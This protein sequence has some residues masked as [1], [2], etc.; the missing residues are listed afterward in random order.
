MDDLTRFDGVTELHPNYEVEHVN[1]EP[2]S[3]EDE[4]GEST[5]GLEQVNAPN[6]W[7]D[8][9]TKG[10]GASVAVLDTG[11]DADHPEFDDFDA[12]ENWKQFDED[13]NVMDVAPNDPNGHGTHVAG[14]VVG[15][16]ESGTNIGV[17]PEAEL[18]AGKVLDNGGTL[19]QIVAGVEWAVEEDVDVVN[20]SL[21]GG[22]YAAVYAEVIDN[23][24]DEGTLVVSSSGN[25]GPGAEGTPANVYSALAVGA[26]DVNEDIADFS[27]GTEIDTEEEWGYIGTQYDWPEEFTT[28]D[29]AAP[30][31]GI[32]SSVPGD[33]Y[34]DTYSGTS[35]A[36]PHASGVAALL[37]AQGADDAWDVK[38]YMQDSAEKPDEPGFQA[39]H[40]ANVYD[41]EYDSNQTALLTDDEE[42]DI[43]YGYG[44]VDAYAASLEMKE[45]GTVEGTVT[46][47]DGEPA[48]VDVWVGAAEAVTDGDGEFSIEVEAGVEHDIVAS[49]FGERAEETVEVDDGEKETV[50]LTL[51]PALDADLID[52]QAEEIVKGDETDISVNVSELETLTVELGSVAENADVEE[53]NI[54][55]E[56]EGEELSLGEE[57][58]ITEGGEPI[59]N[60]IDLTVEIDAAVGAAVDLDLTF[61]NEG[62]DPI[63]VTTGP[64][65]VLEEDAESEDIQVTEFDPPEEAEY[66]DTDEVVATFENP[67]DF[68]ETEE[69]YLFVDDEHD[70]LLPTGVEIDSGEEETV[71]LG[72]MGWWSDLRGDAVPGDLDM[73]VSVQ[74]PPTLQDESN[75]PVDESDVETITVKETEE[76]EEESIITGQVTDSESD[77]PVSGAQVTVTG[78]DEAETRTDIDGEFTASIAGEGNYTVAVHAPQYGVTQ[79]HISVDA[80]GETEV[81]VAITQN[82][83]YHFAMQED[84]VYSFGFPGPVEGE[85]LG[86]V[87]SG[88]NEEEPIGTVWTFDN[89]ENEWSTGSLDTEIGA[90]DAVVVVPEEEIVGE[91]TF[92][93]DPTAGTP[94]S[95]VSSDVDEG[96]NFV[97][98]AQFND[99]EE[100]FTTTS[101][102]LQVQEAGDEP[103]SNVLPDGGFGGVGV[104]DEGDNDLNP[105]AGYFLA[106][107]DDGEQLGTTTDG[108]NLEEANDRLNVDADDLEL[109]VVKAGSDGEPIEGADVTIEADGT[110]WD[111]VTAEDGS[112]SVPQ[113]PAEVEQDVVVEANG[114]ETKETQLTPGDKTLELTADETMFLVDD[115]EVDGD[116]GN[117]GDADQNEFAPGDEIQ[118]DYEV[119]NIGPE[120]DELQVQTEIGPNPGEARMDSD[121]NVVHTE[122]LT[123]ENGT[124]ERISVTEDILDSQV[125]GDQYAAGLSMDMATVPM[126]IET[127]EITVLADEEYQLSNLNPETT[128]VHQEDDPF[129]VSVDVENVGDIAEEPQNIEL[130]ILDSNEEIAYNETAEAVEV[131]A[132]ESTTVE[133]E[134]IDPSEFDGGEY[135]LV[136]S[137]GDDE[138]TGE[139]TVETPAMSELDTLDIADEDENATIVEGDDENISVAVENVGDEAGEFDVDLEINES[140]V[141]EETTTGELEPGETETVTFEAVTGNLSNGSYDIDVSTEDDSVEG[142]LT[143]QELTDDFQVEINDTHDPITEGENLDVNVTVENLGTDDGE[144]TIELEDFGGENVDEENVSLS[145]SDETDISL[146][147][148]TEEGDAGVDNITVTSDNDSVSTEVE[149]EQVATGTLSELDIAEEGTDAMIV[150]GDNENISVAVENVGDE[151]GEFDVNL[152]I[153]ES[154]VEEETTT[155]ELEPDENETV[156]FE[157]VTGNLSDGSYDVDVS[158]EDDSVEGDLT[159]QELTDDFQVEISDTSDPV[160]EGENLDVNVTVENLGTD[161]GEQ[162]IELEDFGGEKVDEENV[163]LDTGDETNIT[164]TWETEEGDAGVDDITVTSDNDS[165]SAGVEIE[166][167][168]TGTLSDLNIAEKSDNATIVE[169]DDENISVVVENVG[170]EAGEFDVTLEINESDI[171]EESSIDEL[172]PDENETITFEAVT[173]NLSD[174]SYDVDVSTEDDTVEGYLTVQELTDDFQIEISD[175]HDPVT[176][177]ENLDVDATVENVGTD[178]GEQT[179]E[180]EDFGGENVD[181]ETVSL[182][183]GDETNITLTWETEE[184]DAGADDITV[185]SDD[186]S[187]STEI[188][189]EQVATAALS[190]L[191][192]AGEGAD[193]TIV[194][195]DNENVSVVVENV[196]DEAGEFDVDLEIGNADVEEDAKTDELEPGETET[197]TFEAVTGNLSNG[198]YDVDV[199]TEDDSIEG[200]LIVEQPAVE[201]VEIEPAEDQIVEAGE[202][203]DFDAT[204][205]DEDGDELET[206]DSEFDWNNADDSGVF[207]E[208]DAGNYEVTAEL[209]GV[210]SETTTVTVESNDIS[211]VE[212][213]PA[214]NQTVAPDEELEFDATALDEFD[215]VVEDNDT[216]FTWT[217]ADESGTFQESDKDDYTVTAELGGVTSEVTTV[218]V[219]EPAVESVEIEP[220]EERTVEAGETIDFDATAFD[221]DGDELETDDSEF[222]WNNADESGVFDETDAGSYD[223]T[224]EFGGVTSESTTVTV[225]ASDVDSVEIDPANDRTVAPDEELE[226]G[227]TALD[228]FDNVVEDDDS[229]FTW[230][231][232]DESGTFQESDEG[233]Y[234]VSAELGGVASESTTVT[235]DS[236]E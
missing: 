49:E 47:A 147:W 166:Q 229:A 192:I 233:D 221:E 91:V 40:D 231:N 92:E 196:G 230:T 195:D 180:L 208:T 159:V 136:V 10:G 174:G 55:V 149:I 216:E 59:S 13:G 223:V 101:E 39:S 209:G 194:E 79:E 200:T 15:S 28:P 20:M 17:A 179:I 98:P 58:D 69:V 50:D 89:E 178:D 222:D 78:P 31:V 150:E 5:Y 224:A 121:T 94:G 45:S 187:V 211:S 225:E 185:T 146:T 118:I 87:L 186:D 155:D 151:A 37:Y 188:E 52:D 204:A 109:T 199:S 177:G 24:M 219:E 126:D 173:G 172:E 86:D 56:Y 42:R 148:E 160:T 16:D 157:A 220:A 93:G 33:G 167:V 110:G 84:R 21:G 212:I 184:G 117:I 36:A 124:T 213:D 63:T 207:D 73:Q 54:A 163:S 129:D 202:T 53:D 23:A 80:G 51:E 57:T 68:T 128:T 183:T 116:E 153:N 82:P 169:G 112:V 132:G 162:T 205:F 72:L 30:G 76:A 141:E 99:P 60:E 227:A 131:D 197:V 6:V 22:G 103:H 168:A 236:G 189:I 102:E 95:P 25:D 1:P 108:L 125:A 44:L 106:V 29:V 38:D 62:D 77:D 104:L 14:T 111:L 35:M 64:T 41:Q 12:D 142:D 182:D 193:A 210:I 19:A 122:S 75:D 123:I 88:T 235:V 190:N 85:T 217:N 43:R 67:G 130:E 48:G 144:Q 119:T 161:D 115:L 96:W 138:I 198:S 9:D 215:N 46:D 158:T 139:L 176:E 191:D 120:A 113:L 114:F 107:D 170:D 134:A 145:A 133:F 232:A 218:T 206:D 152:E 228:E 181:E 175:T 83:N 140:D 34:S 2:D 74:E 61:D 171:E 11:L 7:E 165:V 214:E 100:A 66:G 27:T 4:Y 137:S 105:F 127:E 226:F 234:A 97:A 8:F 154:D 71:P 135:T 81:D 3:L 143:V 90:L 201:S 70:T 32:Y 164:L 65:A 156:T 203:V 18:Y 26:S